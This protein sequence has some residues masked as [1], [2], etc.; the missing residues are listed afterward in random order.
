MY[1]MWLQT[2]PFLRQRNDSEGGGILFEGFLVDVLDAIAEK[3][4]FDYDIHLVSDGLYG[5]RLR[6]GQWNGMVG[7]ITD[8][9]R[10]KQYL[11]FNYKMCNI[12]Q[13]P[14]KNIIYLDLH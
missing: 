13:W 14:I 9:V 6:D 10:H 1:R 4:G 2:P 3:T 7:E 5:S 11:L 8:D 12:L